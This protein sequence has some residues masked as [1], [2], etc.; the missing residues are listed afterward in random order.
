[1]YITRS[2]EDGNTVLQFGDGVH[3][4]RLP[5]GQENVRATY[6]KGVGTGGNVKAGQLTTLL[7]RPLGLKVP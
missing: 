2:D 4:A 5:T 1:M 3:G 7:T 6:R